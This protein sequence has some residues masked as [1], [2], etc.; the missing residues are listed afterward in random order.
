MI[1]Y[2]HVES[3]ER[4]AGVFFHD[5]CRRGTGEPTVDTAACRAA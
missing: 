4:P 2:P 3:G 1:V 5:R